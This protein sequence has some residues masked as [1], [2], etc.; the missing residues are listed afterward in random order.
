MHVYVQI[1]IISGVFTLLGIMG[2]AMSYKYKLKLTLQANEIER[3]NRRQ[4][5]KI[6]KIKNPKYQGP[7]SKRMPKGFKDQ[8]LEWIELMGDERVQGIME[9]LAEHEGEETGDNKIID[10]FIPLAKSFLQGMNEAPDQIEE[11]TQQNY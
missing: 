11:K 9:A 1:S 6:A 4:E 3:Q 5:V 8:I 10:A 2:L 7:G